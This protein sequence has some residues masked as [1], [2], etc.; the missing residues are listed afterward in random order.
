MNNAKL[1]LMGLLLTNSV[2]C[3]TAAMGMEQK[4]ERKFVWT[5]IGRYVNAETNNKLT[6]QEFIRESKELNK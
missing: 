1:R 3:L 6:D 2:F 4:S 5:T